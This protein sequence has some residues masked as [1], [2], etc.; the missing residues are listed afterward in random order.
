MNLYQQAKDQ[1]FPSFCSRDIVD[2]KILQ[3]DWPIAFWRVSQEPDFSQVWDLCKNGG[4]NMNVLY[5]P[6]SEKIND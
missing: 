1:A 4:N 6:N 5:R 3:S 2:L